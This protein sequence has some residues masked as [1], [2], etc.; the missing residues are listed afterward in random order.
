MNWLEQ[1]PEEFVECRSLRHSWVR[2]SF[3]FAPM[4]ELENFTVPRQFDQVVLRRLVCARC[5]TTRLEL[6]GRSKE[7]LR[8]FDRFFV[9][10]YYPDGYNWH[11]QSE[12]EERPSYRDANRELFRRVI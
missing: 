3:R 6:F 2:E 12:G 8:D 1:L 10:Y 4:E 5:N 9:G 7:V 11:R